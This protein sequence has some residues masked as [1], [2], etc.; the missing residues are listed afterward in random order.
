VAVEPVRR[1][2]W[3]ALAKRTFD[4][5][6]SLVVLGLVSPILV[7]AAIAVKFTSPGPLLFSHDRVGLD[8]RRFK[9]YKIRSM[10]PGAEHMV[11]DLRDSNEADGP[12]FKMQDDPRVTSAGRIL[13]SLSVDEIPQLWNVLRGEMSLVGPRPALPS[14]VEQWG[15]EVHQRLHVKP[16]VTGMWQVSGRSNASFEEYVRLDLYYV[17]NWSLWTDIAILAKT[18]PSVLLRR[19]AY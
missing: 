6:G 10:V 2:G 18:L 12:L 17:D 4:I 8:G 15:P 9:L 14:E 7:A 16:G 13:R 19:G 5:L 11:I 3:R 1:G